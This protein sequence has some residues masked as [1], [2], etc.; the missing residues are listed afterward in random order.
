MT[1]VVNYYL[2]VRVFPEFGVYPVEMAG[3]SLPGPAPPWPEDQPETVQDAAARSEQ[4]APND[5]AQP[6]GVPVVI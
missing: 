4:P 3:S 2:R 5:A 1:V 6:G